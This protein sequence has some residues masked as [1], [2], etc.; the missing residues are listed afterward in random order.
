MIYVA[1]LKLTT[2]IITGEN[3][4]EFKGAEST[5]K[6]ITLHSGAGILIQE[7][8]TTT[9]GAIHMEFLK[10]NLEIS[11]AKLTAQT[12]LE[13]ASS[14]SNVE[15]TLPT[16]L[17][18]MNDVL[19]NRPVIVTR[20]YGKIFELHVRNM[21]TINADISLS[22][23]GAT[24][25]DINAKDMTLGSNCDVD[26]S[27][28]SLDVIKIRPYCEGVICEMGLGATTS[29]VLNLDNAELNRLTTMGRVIIGDIDGS[30][31]SLKKIIFDG[32]TY[33][34]GN[35]GIEINVLNA[36]SGSDIIFQNSPSSFTQAVTMK[37]YDSIIS[38]A[39][40]SMSSTLTMKVQNGCGG[41]GGLLLN[42][43]GSFTSNGD[44]TIDGGSL[45]IPP[46][47]FLNTHNSHISISEVCSD[48]DSI[49]LG[50]STSS[51][52]DTANMS[53]FGDEL[54][55]ISAT[56]ITFI[57][58]QGTIFSHGVSEA[59][60]IN[61]SKVILIA[62]ALSFMGNANTFPKLVAMAMTMT[63]S[64]DLSTSAGPLELKFGNGGLTISADIGIT[65]TGGNLHL[66]TSA[67]GSIVTT[68]PSTLRSTT[69]DLLIDVPIMA[70]RNET[71]IRTLLLYAEQKL[72][73]NDNLSFGTNVGGMILRL[74]STK[75]DLRAGCTIHA[76]L[77][78]DV[79]YLTPLCFTA[80]GCSMDFGEINNANWHITNDE[81]AKIT[82]SGMIMIGDLFDT[83]KVQNV[84]FDGVTMTSS[85]ADS[86]TIRTN[87]QHGL[88]VF[89][90]GDT[91]LDL[92]LTVSTGQLTVADGV[93]ANV[94]GILIL[95][96][97]L[98][99]I[100]K[101]LSIG[102]GSI[103]ATKANQNI[104]YTGAD[105]D[106]T[107]MSTALKSGAGNI[108]MIERCSWNSAVKDAVAFGG[109]DSNK[110]V[111][112]LTNTELKTLHANSI[113]LTSKH[114]STRVN[115]I[116]QSRDLP[117]VSGIVIVN[118]PHTGATIDF[119]GDENEV[120]IV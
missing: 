59:N 90:N 61:L 77:A 99:C 60:F 72:V 70:L 113:T 10:G 8:I 38:S 84:N 34:S 35:A 79:I 98:F 47:T 81:I 1:H 64:T 19:I 48:F 51:G 87:E 114:G 46:N 65:A 107:A 33:V 108:T 117:N 76:D 69:A 106:I 94:D 5:F 21:L 20:S 67:S 95:E 50:S 115:G 23:F 97:D 83:S 7:D 111:F 93:A 68:L 42:P 57:S 13:I 39:A 45:S 102:V 43:G 16:S 32:V 109:E 49:G 31:S 29:N 85:F 9:I 52:A 116:K 40:V 37:A 2:G 15:I 25:L 63:V 103:L 53:F 12:D 110:G 30:T 71:V 73:C 105:I 44:M 101:T 27:G 56:D 3:Y 62:D 80:L 91:T 82:T 14:S 17:V 55:R 86:I 4:I 119:N 26:W 78:T 92:T 18:A 54:S 89:K 36:A 88:I 41:S 74:E 6:K 66:E 118:S 75:I 11:S 104:I 100:H 112:T 22:G 28:D 24:I 96:T 58:T 120:C